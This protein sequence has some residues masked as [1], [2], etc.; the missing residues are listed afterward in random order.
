MRILSMKEI[1]I[2]KLSVTDSKIWLYLV[3]FDV[4]WRPSQ[5]LSSSL[6]DEIEFVGMTIEGYDHDAENIDKFKGC[7]SGFGPLISVWTWT[8]LPR[9]EPHNYF[10]VGY[11]VGH[12]RRLVYRRFNSRQER[13]EFLDLEQPFVDHQL[14]HLSH[15]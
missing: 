1:A 4:L 13:Q 9:G 11:S 8:E 15:K 5:F 10:V 7:D 14:F 12:H 3:D 6:M 2:A